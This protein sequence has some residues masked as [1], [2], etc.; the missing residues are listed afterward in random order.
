LWTKRSLVK[1]TSKKWTTYIFC[2]ILF[3]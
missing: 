1:E 3:S 2:F